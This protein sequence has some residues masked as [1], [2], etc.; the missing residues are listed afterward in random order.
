VIHCT[1]MAVAGMCR[2]WHSCGCPAWGLCRSR[3]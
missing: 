3:R 1:R 2:K